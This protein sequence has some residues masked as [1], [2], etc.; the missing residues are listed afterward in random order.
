LRPFDDAGIFQF[1][2]NAGGIRKLAVRGGGVTVVS[3]AMGLA[4]Q[5]IATVVL[6]RLLAP[7]DFGLI[8]MVTTFSL[9]LSN[10]GLNG[11]TEA[12]IQRKVM[13]HG[14]AGNAFWVCFSAGLILTVTFAVS[15]RLLALFYGN[16]RVAPVAAAMS[17]TILLTSSSV[18]HLALLKRAMRFTL[19]SANDVAGRAVLVAVSILLA[20]KGWGYWALVAGSIAQSLS[21]CA[22][23]WFM[24]R[25]IPGRPRRR[26]GTSSVVRFA[27]HTYGRFT[28][29]YGA[30][31]LD[32]V[33]VGWRF[34][35]QSLGFYKKAYDLF[36]LSASQLT[37]PL[38]NVA[39]AVLSRLNHDQPRYRDYL[40]KALSLL[41]FVGMGLAG[42][43]TLAGKDLIRI[44]LGPGWDPAGRIFTFFGPGVGAML[45]YGIH[46]WIHLSIGRADRW[47]RWSMVEFGVTSLLFVL[48]LPWGPAGVALAWTASFWI[49]LLPAFWYAGRPIG[50]GIAP[51]IA[52]TWRP[53][54]ASLLAGCV[55][56]AIIPALPYS[57]AAG[58]FA[59]MAE[60]SAAFATLYLGAIILLHQSVAPLSLV[61]RLAGELT[62]SSRN[63]VLSPGDL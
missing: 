36:A 56:A 6:A 16:P 23:A 8:A 43:L 32:N 22:G 11:F 59:H 19:V 61:V 34:D 27:L 45:L 25:W 37:A 18:L 10:F 52:A 3:S 62:R 54:L 46:G 38:G 2:A 7:A 48:G 39:V 14:L 41:A 30:R 47:F 58:A 21:Q 51:V 53:V 57:S 50:L 9:L 42:W 49:L 40:L 1:P 4:V 20:W 28:V 17:L 63:L 29:N 5:M 12:V 24:C 55:S 15:G 60:V 35:A 44:L 33:L 13:N 26:V 31:N